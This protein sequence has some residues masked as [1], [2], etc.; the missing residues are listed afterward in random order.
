MAASQVLSVSATVWSAAHL[1][2]EMYELEELKSSS[3]SA[4]TKNIRR[5]TIWPARTPKAGLSTVVALMVEYSTV[6]KPNGVAGVVKFVQFSDEKVCSKT[7]GDGAISPLKR[8]MKEPGAP[9]PDS[10]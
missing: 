8:G 6:Q 3:T 9:A 2:T 7:C 1:A 5:F 10:K 4:D